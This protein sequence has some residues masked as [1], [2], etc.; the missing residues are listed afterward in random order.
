[1]EKI[2]WALNTQINFSSLSSWQWIPNTRLANSL[3]WINATNRQRFWIRRSFLITKTHDQPWCPLLD[4]K[5]PL[6]NGRQLQSELLKIGVYPLRWRKESLGILLFRR[7]MDERPIINSL[8]VDWVA[9]FTGIRNINLVTILT[10]ALTLLIC[11]ILP[12][13]YGFHQWAPYLLRWSIIRCWSCLWGR[14]AI[15]PDFKLSLFWRIV[16][17]E[18]NV[19]K[20]VIH[21]LQCGQITFIYSV[22]TNTVV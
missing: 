20:N 15:K 21:D 3:D 19:R 16:I 7:L 9:T 4:V 6:M 12:C 1:M 2:W 11:R 13:F 22:L 10:A 17:S 8:P 18:I 14:V 5:M